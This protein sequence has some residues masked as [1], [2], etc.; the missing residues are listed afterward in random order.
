MYFGGILHSFSI[1]RYG[2]LGC[3]MLALETCRRLEH[4][5]H[6]WLM[7]DDD[8][9]VFT[10]ADV[11]SYK[12]ELPWVEWLLAQDREGFTWERAHKVKAL[13]PCNP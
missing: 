13:A 3:S 8:P 11:N 7:A 6:I 4:Y 2:E 9:Y 12:E 1:D 5:Y 10:D